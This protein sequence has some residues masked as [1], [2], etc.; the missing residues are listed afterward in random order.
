MAINT[1]VLDLET[2]D[3]LSKLQIAA[4]SIKKGGIVVFPTETVYGL[5]ANALDGDAVG[6]IFTAKGRP[7]DNPLIA[8][9]SSFEAARPYIKNMSAGANLLAKAFMP[10]PLTLVVNKGEGISDNA[11]CGLGTVGIRIPSNADARDFLALSGVPIVAPSANVSGRPS[12][13]APSHVIND[14]DGKVDV[15]LLGG[16]CEFGVESTV[17][18]CSKEPFELLRPGAVSLSDLR[19]FAYVEHHDAGEGQK[20]KSPGMKY[21]HYKPSASVIALDC[22]HEAAVGI[23]NSGCAGTTGT[24][25]LV[26]EEFLDSAKAPLVLSLGS[27]KDPSQAAK[28]LF[29]LLRECDLAGMG[30]IY[31]MC[32]S[33]E[34]IGL[35]YRNRLFKAADNIIS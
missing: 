28:K 23:I 16:A 10:G 13:T 27:A 3:R 32:P 9:F 24:A 22:P 14:M 19:R 11:T 5:G 6:K 17:V 35:A 8:H 34:G 4:E 18:D 2:G 12:P 30:R 25:A 29:A 1:L 33:D 15:I 21:Q 7:A 26:F 20:P 31:A